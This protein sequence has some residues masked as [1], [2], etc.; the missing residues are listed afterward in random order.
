MLASRTSTQAGFTLVEILVALALITLLAV[1]ISLTFDGSRSRAQALLTTMT[2]LSS[3]NIRLKN[4]TGC[5]AAEPSLLFN[6]D[7]ASVTASNFCGKN[8]IATWNGP[9]VAPFTLSG[10]SVNL[11]RVA[12][13]VVVDFARM[14]GVPGG[15]WGATGKKYV[16]SATNLPDDVVRQALMECNGADSDAADYTGRKCIGNAAAGTFSMLFDETR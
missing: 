13:G 8:L 14:T 5:Y 15:A 11:D 4:D 9:Y 7:R 12:D 10:Q 16:V 2:E 6:R 1:G 3:A